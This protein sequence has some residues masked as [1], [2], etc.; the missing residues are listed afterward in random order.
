MSRRAGVLLVALAAAMLVYCALR[1]RVGTDLTRFLPVSSSSELAALSGLL[2]DSPLA[3][4]VVVSIGA[5]E[6]S[7]AI[8]AARELAEELHGHPE[9]AWVRSEVD[10]ADIEGFYQ[11][12]F[13]RR[14]AF[15][16]SE[17]ERD[18]PARL[19]DAALRE[20]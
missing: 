7:V 16:S 20:R 14:L 2:A 1:L 10:E 3:R 18:L 12:Y 4:T 5:D 6:P 15:L 9:V 13:P 17:P 19:G 8:A 11:L